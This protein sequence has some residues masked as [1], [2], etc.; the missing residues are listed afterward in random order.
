MKTNCYYENGGLNEDVKAKTFRVG[1][2]ELCYA[3]S[4]RNPTWFYVKLFGT[5]HPGATAFTFRAFTYLI[6]FRW[7]RAS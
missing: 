7:Y 6:G 5:L 2:L 1:R 4:F 3:R